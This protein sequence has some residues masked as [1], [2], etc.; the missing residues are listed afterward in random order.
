MLFEKVKPIF[1]AGSKMLTRL[2]SQVRSCNYLFDNVKNMGAAL[3]QS[4][5]QSLNVF[6]SYDWSVSTVAGS[7]RICDQRRFYSSFVAEN[8][9]LQKPKKISKSMK[10]SLEFQDLLESA[11]EVCN[12]NL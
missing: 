8:L 11:Y 1:G 10:R 12:F 7:Q 3:N 4:K 5:S 2:F 9:G 6:K